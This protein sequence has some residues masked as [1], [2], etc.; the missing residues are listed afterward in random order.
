M[1]AMAAP[2]EPVIDM[3]QASCDTGSGGSICRLVYD[4]TGSERAADWSVWLVER[5]LKVLLV[6][7]ATW[8]GIRLGKRAIHAFV[9]TLPRRI[10]RTGL[11]P[12]EDS[13]ERARAVKESISVEHL[14][15]NLLRAVAWFLAVVVALGIFGI[16]VWPLIMSAGILALALSLGAQTVVRD[17]I[18]GVSIIL[19]G[20]VAVGDAVDLADQSGKVG[21]SGTVEGVGLSSTTVRDDGGDLWHIPNGDIRWVANRSGRSATLAVDVRV[22]Y[23]TDLR[24]A[25]NA[26]AA[27]IAAVCDDA[28]YR[29]AVVEPPPAP[30]VQD[31]GADAVV[32]RATLVV[33]R[34]ALDA[35]RAATLERVARA[36][37]E[38]Q[39]GPAL[40]RQV[41]FLGEPT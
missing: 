34:K 1:L 3:S 35:I 33:E 30:V 23:G 26:L 37:P 41:V 7:I 15:V 32:L 25:K 27:A 40:P 29:D 24:A 18:G 10:Q 38:A 28:T 22:A 6:V 39:L 14:L 4:L 5:P 12:E 9:I 21:V 17:L 36:M 13:R 20:R 8:I 16:N 11:T 31:L 2:T 19:D